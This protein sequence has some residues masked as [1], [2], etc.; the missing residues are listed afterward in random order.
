VVK[1]Y[2]VDVLVVG[3]GMAGV[4]AAITSAGNGMNTM[5]IEM[6]D[7]L[8][9]FNT[10]GLSSIPIEKVGLAKEIIDKVDELTKSFYYESDPE[11]TKL[12]NFYRS[13]PEIAKFVLEQ[14]ILEAGV[15]LLYYTY[16]T[17]VVIE[18]NYI[19][20]VTA[21]N[22]SGKV[23]IRAKIFI[24]AT[25]SAYAGVPCEA[26]GKEYGG[27]NMSSTLCFRMTHVN[28]RKYY[29]AEEAWCKKHR[30]LPAFVSFIAELEDEAFKKR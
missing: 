30:T 6:L 13:D 3:G 27:L 7:S 28:L 4:S 17:D 2:S 5:L 1:E 11:I 20:E 16:A 9:G 14:M 8:G 29:G 24:D 19:K 22:K 15:K 25:I 10:N 18:N 12:K 21:Y 26:G 23:S